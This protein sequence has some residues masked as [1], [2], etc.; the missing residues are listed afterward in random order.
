MIRS[1]SDKRSPPERWR[2][3]VNRFRRKPSWTRFARGS[4]KGVT[5][6]T[7][8]EL[9]RGATMENTQEEFAATP[10]SKRMASDGSNDPSPFRTEHDRLQLLLEVTSALAFNTDPRDLVT[11]LSSGLR[12]VIRHESMGLALHEDGSDALVVQATALPLPAGN[13]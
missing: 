10:V 8:K 5:A 2:S 6:R 9:S 3:F 12:R 4:P 7:H 1:R 13:K 11:A